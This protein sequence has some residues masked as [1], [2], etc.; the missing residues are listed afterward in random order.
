M[1]YHDVYIEQAVSQKK[2]RINDGLSILCVV[3]ILWTLFLEVATLNLAFTI[4]IVIF[5]ALIVY[6]QH[7]KQTDFD[8]IYTNGVLEIDR[9]SGGTKR[10]NLFTI[11][12]E[13][14]VVIA[15]SKTEP[16]MPYVGKRMKTLDCTSHE[17]VPYYTMILHNPAKDED[18]KILWEP[19]EE[20][21]EEFKRKQNTK[22]FINKQ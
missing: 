18:W 3:F 16:V 9:I 11:D 21:L 7:N 2:R 6:L 15:P 8:Y 22:V 5:I 10:K 17:E 14:L 19:K 12:I 20:F 4:L 1:I 13:H